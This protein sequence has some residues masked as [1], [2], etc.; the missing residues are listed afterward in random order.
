M[1]KWYVL[2]LAA[3]PL[4][5]SFARSPQEP[6]FLWWTT[7]ALDQVRPYDPAPRE[8]NHAVKLK[9]ARNE[10]EPFQVVF[11]AQGQDFSAIDVDVTDLRGPAG[12]IPANAFIT[13]YLE[14]YLD[15]KTPSSIEGG[16][17]EWP[18][19]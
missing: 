16:T 14:Q 18:D 9:A 4:L 11:R 6:E 7:H 5:L 3:I 17:G 8:L 19:P 2:G 13:V 15:L 10:F 1:N 12:S